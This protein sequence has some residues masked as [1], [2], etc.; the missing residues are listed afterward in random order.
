MRR[1]FHVRFCEGPGVQFPR[2][3]RLAIGFEREDDAKRVRD[4]LGRRFEKFGLKLHPDKTRLLPFRRPPR[5]QTSGKGPATFDFL[6]F[7]HFWCRSRRGYW[8]PAL[9][10]RTARLRR[11]I[12]AVADWCRRHRH[13]SV[14][15]QHAGLTRRIDGHC[16]YFGVNG[17][18]RA[19]A[20]LIHHVRRAWHKWLCR[21]SQRGRMSWTRFEQLLQRYPLPLPTIRVQLWATP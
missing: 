14:E 10:T 1:E 7:T 17:N 15:G 18:G 11:A 9:K 12:Q 2:A 13:Q 20:L 16:N 8:V 3:T 19:L 4:V 5:G 6:G 21:R